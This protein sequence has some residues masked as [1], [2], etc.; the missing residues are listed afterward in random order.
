MHYAHPRQARL[1]GAMAAVRA[2]A[3]LDEVA[4][5]LPP[6]AT[7]HLRSGEFAARRFSR[8]RGA[9]AN[10]AVLG[11]ECAFDLRLVAPRL[12]PF[13]VG[14]GHTED[15]WLRELTMRGAR[16]RYG[17]PQGEPQAYA[18]LEHE[19]TVIA[20]L[21]F[22]GYFLIVASLVQFCRERGIYCQGRGSAANS[23]V[24]YALGVTTVDPVK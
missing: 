12:P 13:P 16:D 11:L 20:Q 21:G 6:G 17:T 1:A 5:W 19:L 22:A 24:C 4:G 9:V 14:D 2:R 3:S 10:A 8:F 18:Q 23:A 15:S 7:R